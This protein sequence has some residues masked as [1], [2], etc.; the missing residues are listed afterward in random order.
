MEPEELQTEL[1]MT[2]SLT[3]GQQSSKVSQKAHGIQN[4]DFLEENPS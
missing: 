1:C 3:V 4:N 2:D